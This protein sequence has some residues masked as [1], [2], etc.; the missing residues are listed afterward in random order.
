MPNALLFIPDIS[1]YTQFIT[2][3]EISHQQH[4]IAELLEILIDSNDIGLELAEV[5][6]DALFMYKLEPMPSPEEILELV[7]SMFIKFHSHLRYYDKYRVCHC[8]ACEGA[9]GLNLK[10]VIHQGEVGFLK[11][12]DLQPKPQGKEVILAHRLLKNSI[13]SKEYLLITHQV[14]QLSSGHMANIL[15]TDL[16]LGGED[17]FGLEDVG[18]VDYNYIELGQLKKLVNDPRELRPSHISDHPIVVESLINIPPLELFEILINFE[19]RTKWTKGVDKI[20]YDPDEVNKSGTQHLC[21][22]DGKEISFETIKGPD[23]PEVWSFGEKSKSP[24]IGEMYVYF[25]VY[26][27][28]EQSHLKIEV[29]PRPDNLLGKLILP[30]M[31]RKIKSIFKEVIVGIKEYAEEIADDQPN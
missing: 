22:I 5:E 20:E 4:I 1:G 7:K 28:E 18:K 25:L 11:I 26:P 2:R 21:V 31:R 13:D 27:K 15:S 19:H 30:I 17:N 3:T 8:G 6:G 29:H 10:F 16:V 23:I 9:T 12:K 14:E 24:P